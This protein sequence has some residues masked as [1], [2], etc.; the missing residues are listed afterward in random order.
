MAWYEYDKLVSTD[1]GQ[2][3]YQVYDVGGPSNKSYVASLAIS[4]RLD[5]SFRIL[6]CRGLN[7]SL[8]EAQDAPLRLLVLA[9]VE[10]TF[11]FKI[12][13]FPSHFNNN[14]CDGPQNVISYYH[15]FVLYLIHCKP[16]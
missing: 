3:F 13:A 15:V 8:D 10:G 1:T 7:D 2:P 6:E 4:N 11:P 5:P 16:T 14:I 12:Q 9:Y